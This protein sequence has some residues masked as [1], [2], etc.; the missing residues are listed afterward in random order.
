MFEFL[1]LYFVRHFPNLSAFIC[2]LRLF[3]VDAFIS[4]PEKKAQDGGVLVIRLDAIGDYMLFRQCL[5][6][7]RCVPDFQGKKITL[8]GNAS[9][10]PLAETLDGDVFDEFLPVERIRLLK[11]TVYRHK[12]MKQLRRKNFSISLR[13]I[14]SREYS[15]ECLAR[16][17]HAKRS[18]AFDGPAQNISKP[19]LWFF[20]LAI[21]ELMPTSQKQLFEVERNREMLRHLGVRSYDIVPF[22]CT[23]TEQIHRNIGQEVRL[24][25]GHPAFFM[26]AQS[27]QRRWN[28]LKFAQLAR[29]VAKRFGKRVLLLGG[30]DVSTEM[31][32]VHDLV[33]DSTQILEGTSLIE[34]VALI[35][36]ASILISHDSSGCHI[37]AAYNTPTIIL[38]NGQHRGRFTPYPQSTCSNTTTLYPKRLKVTDNLYFKSSPYSIDDINVEDVIEAMDTLLF[39]INHSMQDT[40]APT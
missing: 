34:L 9:W 31:K 8:C 15:G 28:S 13:P 12:L 5:R 1:K 39:E 32:K 4:Y 36:K 27:A 11:D 14:F 17:A 20:N 26:G 29:Y 22:K 6:S 38:S 21:S 2:E 3:F 19:L 40:S 16:A 30:L 37:G 18:I 25:Y 24:F 35:A 33:P 10:Q 7:L 23:L